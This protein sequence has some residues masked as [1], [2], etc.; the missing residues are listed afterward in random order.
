MDDVTELLQNAANGDSLSMDP[1][2]K[3]II[4]AEGVHFAGSAA[5]HE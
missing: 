1:L 3:L 2:Y 4:I 5:T